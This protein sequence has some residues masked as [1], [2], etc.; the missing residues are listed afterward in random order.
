MNENVHVSRNDS[1][2]LFASFL[3]CLYTACYTK[4]EQSKG[5]VRMNKCKSCWDKPCLKTMAMFELLC[6]EGTC[7]RLFV[8]F[9]SFVI[10][11]F[12]YGYMYILYLTTAAV[13]ILK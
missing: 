13:P 7:L 11:M 4:N 8:L 3:R 12:L 1:G 6:N 5:H 10:I 9:R 2:E